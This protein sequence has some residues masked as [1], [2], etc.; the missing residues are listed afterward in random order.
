[1]A[2]IGDRSGS[3]HFPQKPDSEQPNKTVTVTIEKRW[4]VS[5][6]R[7]VFFFVRSFFFSSINVRIFIFVR[8]FRSSADIVVRDNFLVEIVPASILTLLPF[9]SHCERFY[10]DRRTDV[11]MLL[12]FCARG[13]QLYVI[14]RN[15]IGGGDFGFL[16][17]TFCS[18][19]NFVERF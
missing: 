11:F 6:L 16:L 12:C 8:N 10:I 18:L 13:N 17:N 14:I 1:M 7:A 9:I 3:P 2:D 4:V 5:R 19:R 15:G